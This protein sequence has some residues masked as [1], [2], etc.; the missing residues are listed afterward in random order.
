MK[1]IVV[2]VILG[3]AGMINGCGTGGATKGKPDLNG[4]AAKKVF[5][6]LKELKEEPRT[7]MLAE[8]IEVAHKG[9]PFSIAIRLHR[10]ELVEE[11]INQGFDP[12]AVQSNGD[13]PLLVAVTGWSPGFPLK[14]VELILAHKPDPNFLE[15]DGMGALHHASI[16]GYKDVVD[17]LLQAGADPNLKATVKVLSRTPLH[18]AVLM[19]RKEVAQALIKAGAKADIKDTQGKTALDLAK[20]A[21]K[22]DLVALLQGK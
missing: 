9:H 10:K 4:P 22:E 11:L 15:P 1:S 2:F 20:D 12:K 18:A 21:K 16:A 5:E 19:G 8:A 13:F 17:L 3:I 6:I 7:K 14:T